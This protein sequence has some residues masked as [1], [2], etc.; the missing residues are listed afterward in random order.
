MSPARPVALTNDGRGGNVILGKNVDKSAKAS[1]AD[2]AYVL[3]EAA[4]TGRYDGMA[5]DMQSA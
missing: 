4:T 5:Q 3:A 1:R 2:V